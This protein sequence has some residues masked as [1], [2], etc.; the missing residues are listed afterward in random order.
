MKEFLLWLAA[1]YTHLEI[2]MKEVE[3]SISILKRIL[4]PRMAPEYN[5]HIP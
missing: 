2:E 5:P 4:L 3:K 1:D